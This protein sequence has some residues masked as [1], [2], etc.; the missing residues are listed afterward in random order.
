MTVQQ[1]RT[2]KADIAW[3]EE[4]KYGPPASLESE[5]RRG[6]SA[7]YEMALDDM[8]KRKSIQ[9]EVMDAAI[10]DRFAEILATLRAA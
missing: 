1:T 10:V 5:Y 3:P 6:F 8:R 7:G 2:L 4:D 9:R